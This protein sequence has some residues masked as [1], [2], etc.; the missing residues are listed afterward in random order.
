MRVNVVLIADWTQALQKIS[1]K[2]DFRSSEINL[3]NQIDP[4]GH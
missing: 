4:N 2:S 3:K 1:L